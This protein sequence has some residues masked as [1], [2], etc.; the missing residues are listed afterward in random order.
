[1]DIRGQKN[2]ST[3]SSF[4]VWIFMAKKIIALFHFPRMNIHGQKIIALFQ[5]PR[6]DI[7]GQQ[8]YSTFAVPIVR[9]EN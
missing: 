5:F 7:H 3:F 6:V 9:S 4:R 2:Y 8:N 1:M